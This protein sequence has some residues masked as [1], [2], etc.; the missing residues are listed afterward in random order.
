MAVSLRSKNVLDHRSDPADHRTLGVEDGV[1]PPRAAPPVSRFCPHP[2]PCQSLSLK[3]WL[4]RYFFGGWLSWLRALSPLA[5]SFCKHAV[6]V[7]RTNRT[8]PHT[9]TSESGSKRV[10]ARASVVSSCFTTE[11]FCFEA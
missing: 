6:Y 5:M 2:L 4:W 11:D 8:A 3:I 9:A 7:K 10:Q 1:P